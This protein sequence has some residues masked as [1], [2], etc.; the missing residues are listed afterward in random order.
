MKV[1]VAGSK[2]AQVRGWD[3]KEVCIFSYLRDAR[4]S[5]GISL[6][7]RYSYDALCSLEDLQS[8]IDCSRDMLSSIYD[9]PSGKY[10]VSSVQ[11]A[12]AS[13]KP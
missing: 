13:E 7:R 6:P 9:S 4:D 1:Q 2:T 11:R 8:T 12:F 3:F 10:M 5:L